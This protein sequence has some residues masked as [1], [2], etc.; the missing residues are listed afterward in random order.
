M[1]VGLPRPQR[2]RREGAAVEARLN[3]SDRALG[4]HAGGVIEYWSDPMPGEIRDDQGICIKN[5]DTGGF[6]RYKLAGAYDSNVALLISVG[7]ER[8][9]SF[10]NLAEILRGTKLVGSDL[11]T[12]LQFHYGLVSFFLGTN[13]HARPTTGFVVPYLTQVG[14][15][16][17]EAKKVDTYHAYKRLIESHER[18]AHRL[19]SDE[20]KLEQALTALRSILEKKRTLILRP[21]NLILK[22]PHWFSG[23][24]STNRKYFDI[25]DG[26]VKWHVN[27]VKVLSDTYHILDMDKKDRLPAAQMIWQQDAEMLGKAQAF[28]AA[29]E[30]KL[31]LQSAPYE[32]LTA[33]L[34]S[35]T[36]PNGISYELWNK[37]RAAHQGHQLGLELLD[38]LP[39]VAERAGFFEL[40]VHDDLSVH[41]PERLKDPE[42]Q[43]RMR[44]VLVPPPVSKGDEIVAETGGMFY[45][46]E[47][48]DQPPLL[49]VGDKFT[50]GQ[51][52]Y[53]I[54]VM[55][56]FNKIQANFSGTVEKV[57]VD[58]DGT[59][60]K[61]G[62]PL[63]KVK[64]DI[65]VEE[66][67]PKQLAATIREN[68]DALVSDHIAL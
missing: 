52:L 16:S 29:L 31:G 47:A 65:V 28:Y 22:D 36:A 27:P 13:V 35:T 10:E 30:K 4:P 39:V 46:K 9:V 25:V 67:D 42:L 48:P 26:R 18:A 54:E 62:T 3:A 19:S 40:T 45:S 43:K 34:S 51:P 21:I 12:N 6:I 23:W 53:V 7:N 32:E 64:P 8:K 55:K 50:V 33:A 58:K 38:L 44:R 57:L 2:F 61:K 15:L 1:A 20:E 59:I 60:V 24:L 66:V 5:P 56:M 68:T 37:I 63:F 17:E 41:I 49:N 14:L 11:S